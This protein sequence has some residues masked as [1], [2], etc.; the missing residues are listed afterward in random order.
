MRFRRF[1]ISTPMARDASRRQGGAGAREDMEEV[2]RGQVEILMARRVSSTVMTAGD[3]LWVQVPGGI[4]QTLQQSVA[5][6][7]RGLIRRSFLP[8]VRFLLPPW[9]QMIVSHR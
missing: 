3:A 7:P 2:S 9:V 5:E 8:G 1:L 4:R 6:S